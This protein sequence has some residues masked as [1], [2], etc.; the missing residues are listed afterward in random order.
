MPIFT[1][2]DFDPFA[3]VKEIERIIL[4]N[5]PQREIWLSCILGGDEANLSYNESVS[6]D[7]EG[8]LH[9]PAFERAV[10]DLIR[11]HEALRSTISPNGETLIIYKNEP[12][13]LG[14]IDLTDLD[15]AGK[16]LELQSFIRN[17]IN[18][19][20]DIK[21]GPLLKFFL[22]KLANQ[23]YFFTI[24]KHHIIGDGWS[25]GIMLED[26][27]RMYNAY[28]KGEEA[29]LGKAYQL[30]DYAA[31]QTKFKASAEYKETENF[32]L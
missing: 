15:E 24:I 28:K 6:L 16:S 5:E 22:H 30:S 10:N 14:L 17:E 12:V 9:I 3:E 18:T 13:K 4:T 11:R 21:E 8:D 23:Q 27:S 7:I 2:I 1:P 25:T 19:P 26:L 31:E 29:A 32:W 20:L